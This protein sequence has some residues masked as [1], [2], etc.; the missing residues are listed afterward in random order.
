MNP[1]DRRI[2][3]LL[4]ALSLGAGAASFYPQALGI[5]APITGAL[6]IASISYRWIYG[7][8]GAHKKP[9]GEKRLGLFLEKDGTP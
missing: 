3:N 2:A 5:A 4:T 9:E 7:G 1:T 8:F 6:I